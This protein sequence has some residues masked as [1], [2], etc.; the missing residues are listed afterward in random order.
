[1]K[2]MQC[3]KCLDDCSIKNVV[4][5]AVY[6]NYVGGVRYLCIPCYKEFLVNS[7]RPER[8]ES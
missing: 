1:M 5:L 6:I 8:L 3:M 2:I 4:H 7:K